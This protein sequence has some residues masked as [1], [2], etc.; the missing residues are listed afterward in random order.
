MRRTVDYYFAPQ[1]PWMY[2]GHE[3]FA[4]LLQRTDTQVRVLP[5]DFGKVFPVSGGLPLPQR[6]P[7]RQ[8]YRLVELRRFSEA[9][10]I[11]LNPQPRCFPVAGDPAG[12]LITAVAEQDGDA[13]AMRLT[14]AVGRA[15]W[16][17]ERD[18]AD[19]TV[20]AELLDE[21]GLDPQRL[22]QSQQDGAK[23][24]YAAHTAQAIDAG[25]FGAPSYVIDGEVFWGQDRLDFVERR[26]SV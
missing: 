11:P 15:V 23:A 5:V 10:G 2:L 7:Q 8:A 18:I 6:A 17:Q 13:A 9:L 20:L 21:C 26:L 12:W 14:G 1:S 3:R 24:L 4:D 22:A 25:V 16:A 19:A